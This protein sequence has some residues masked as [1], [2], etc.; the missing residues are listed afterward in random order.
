M[1]L[2]L[3]P[4][5]IVRFF[6]QFSGIKKAVHIRRERGRGEWHSHLVHSSQKRQGG[7]QAGKP[8]YPY[9]GLPC[10]SH[11]GAL[12]VLLDAKV[13]LSFFLSSASISPDRPITASRSSSPSLL[14]SRSAS[15]S[16]PS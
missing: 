13:Y 15:V 9:D 3:Y 2:Y 16:L 7:A 11:Q 10:S 14:T 12:L 8:P 1:F 5:G 6:M 4:F